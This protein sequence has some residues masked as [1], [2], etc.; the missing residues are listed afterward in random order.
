MTGAKVNAKMMRS[1]AAGFIRSIFEVLVF[2]FDP[3]VSM[4]RERCSR[5]AAATANDDISRLVNAVVG[6]VECTV[7]G[8]PN[9]SRQRAMEEFQVDALPEAVQKEKRETRRRLYVTRQKSIRENLDKAILRRVTMLQTTP[10]T[11]GGYTADV[12]AL[13]KHAR[14]LLES[15]FIEDTASSLNQE[16]QVLRVEVTKILL[17]V[18]RA[19]GGYFLTSA[20]AGSL[21]MALA[22][23]LRTKAGG[24]HL[25]RLHWGGR[26]R[27]ERGMDDADICYKGTGNQTASISGP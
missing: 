2:A 20:F 25:D 5:D 19:T 22:A 27:V 14:E 9:L 26:Q 12:V 13:N 4:G 24:A 17:A 1:S 11:N 16:E 7:K 10:D 15:A 8:M 23:C 21:A 6:S 18:S 3:W